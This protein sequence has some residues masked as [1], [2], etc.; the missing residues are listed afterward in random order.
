[1]PSARAIYSAAG[2]GL[3]TALAAC[4]LAWPGRPRPRGAA[5]WRVL[6]QAGLQPGQFKQPRGITGLPDGSFVVVDRAARVQRFDFSGR[7]VSLWEMPEREWGNPKGLCALP[8]GGLLVCDTHYGR[9]LE[10]T[11]DGATVKVWGKPG[12]GEGQFT[13][14]LSCC[15]DARRGV[16]Y[17]VEYGAYNDRVQKFALDG[18]FLKAWGT[19]GSEPGQFRRPSGVAVDSQGS[20]YVADAVNHRIQKFTPEGAVLGCIGEQ[21]SGPGQLSYPY[22]VACAPDDTLFVAD[23]DNHRVSVFAPDGTFLRVLGGPGERA[24]EFRFPWSLTIDRRGRLLVSDTGNH[25]V[26]VLPL[27]PIGQRVSGQARPA[28]E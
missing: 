6:G 24:G 4:L 12:A 2:L 8:D 5:G 11:L 14:P 17:V 16:A 13:L 1:M 15:V 25:R 21:G 28:A 9:V 3:L 20:V 23:W 26:Q 7:A 10:M 18:T 22:D 19:F 27:G